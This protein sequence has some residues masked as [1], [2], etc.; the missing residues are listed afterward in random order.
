MHDLLTKAL[1]DATGQFQSMLAGVIAYAP[2]LIAGI[3]VG[4]ASFIV[5]RTARHWGER[6]VRRAHTHV[7]VERLIVNTIYAVALALAA[8]VTLAVLGVN[9]AGMIAGL[10]VG[11][12]VIGFALKDI[13][14]NLLAGALLL[15]QQPFSL[16]DTIQV[17]DITG[18]VTHIELRA[19]TMNAIDGT[20]VIIPNRDVYTSVITNYTAS[21]IRRRGVSLGIGYDEKLPAA[22]DALM[23]AARG[24]EGV[25]TDPEPFFAMD[26]FGDSAITGTL[27]YYINTE[28]D[29]FNKTH[30][31]V[32]AALQDVANTK[33]ID[34]PYPTSIV[35]N[36]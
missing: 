33:Q 17:E 23:G 11:G 9:V 14:E 12:L 8:V 32:L 3:I 13:I 6:A 20:N 19:T 35:I 26:D 31:R 5:A 30:A 18:T 21:I 24:V 28:N 25:A 2:T 16:G 29:D 1:A 22:L 34:L 4:V 27:F 10:G 36:R 15:I 7:S